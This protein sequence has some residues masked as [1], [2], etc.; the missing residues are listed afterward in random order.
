MDSNRPLKVE[1]FEEAHINDE[2]P[3]LKQNNI[4]K[5]SP[6]RQNIIHNTGRESL[7]QFINKKNV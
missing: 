1:K 2:R 4:N 6:V 3:F 7:N 5:T